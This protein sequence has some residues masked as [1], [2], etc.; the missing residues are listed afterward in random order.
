MTRDTYDRIWKD[1]GE[2]RRYL[3]PWIEN[4]PELLPVGIEDGFQRP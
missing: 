3:Q 4:S 1:A 2:V